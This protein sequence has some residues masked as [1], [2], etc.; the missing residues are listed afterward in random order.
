MKDQ[1]KAQFFAQYL[2]K[3]F[4]E[5]G[6]EFN[7]EGLFVNA[8][9]EEGFVFDDNFD[10][11]H[12]PVKDCCLLLR[13]VEQLTGEELKAV[14]NNILVL[15]DSD[16]L[17]IRKNGDVLVYKKNNELRYP[18]VK[19]FQ[20]IDQYFLRIGILLPFTYLDENNKPVTLSPAEIIE[21]G[22]A[23]IKTDN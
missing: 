2:G 12:F 18:D 1:I 19:G 7:N 21:L 5:L 15:L 13:S 3:P 9:N 23:K 16:E 22:W 6:C 10:D 20:K 14:R 17:K 4:E 8:V 11:V